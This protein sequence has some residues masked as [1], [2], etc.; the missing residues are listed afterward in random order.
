M[1]EPVIREVR[2]EDAPDILD[3]VVLCDIAEIG[4]PDYTIEDVEE[5][6]ARTTLQGWVARDA[7]GVLQGHCWLEKRSHHTDLISDVLIRPGGDRRLAARLLEQVRSAARER[8]PA[9]GLHMFANP[10]N[11]AKSTLLERAGATV[12]R[13][14]RRMDIEL[15]DAP[16]PVVPVLPAGVELRPADRGETD[17]RSVHHVINAAF[18]DHFGNQDSSYE[19]WAPGHIAGIW[20]DHTLWW[21]ATVDGELAAAQIAGRYPEGGGHIADLGTLREFRGRGLGRALLLTA[22]AEFHRRGERKVS[23][24][25]DASNPSGAVALYES[26]GMSTHH[27]AAL[28]EFVPGR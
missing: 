9:S 26:V 17:L 20:G 10:N 28:Y 4:E 23:L 15:P 25:V 22:F 21:I 8:E 7:D 24:G 18:L 6:L 14:F 27:Q 1:T 13:H 12:V 2:P 3:L 5:D 11:R 16:A 19:D